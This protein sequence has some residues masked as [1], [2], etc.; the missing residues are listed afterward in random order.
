MDGRVIFTRVKERWGWRER[1]PCLFFLFLSP[2]VGAHAASGVPVCFEW[3][4]RL[5]SVNAL[6]ESILP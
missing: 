2:R 1:P 4:S 6:A 5:L 3:G